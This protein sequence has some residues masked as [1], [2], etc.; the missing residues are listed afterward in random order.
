MTGPEFKAAR[1]RLGLTL[2]AVAKRY[3]V[4]FATVAH[5]EREWVSAPRW[6]VRDASEWLRNQMRARTIKGRP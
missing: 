4:S 3:G 1:K 2:D 5:F 6:D